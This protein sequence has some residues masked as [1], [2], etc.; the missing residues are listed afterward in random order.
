MRDDE[1]FEIDRAFDLL[2]HV[3]GASWATIWFRMNRIRRPSVE[4]FRNKVAEYY[5]ML[6]SLVDVYS[7]DEKFADMTRHIKMRYQEEM[8]RILKG[9]NQ[10]IEKRF[11]RYLDYG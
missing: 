2:P 6:D 7:Q 11:K 8:D 1:G 3:V 9:K 10:E 4:E 5:K